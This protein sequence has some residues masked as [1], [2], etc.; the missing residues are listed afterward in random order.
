MV[1]RVGESD[2]VRESENTFS[3]FLCEAEHLLGKAIF[4]IEVFDILKV[5]EKQGL[6]RSLLRSEVGK[7]DADMSEIGCKNV[8]NVNKRIRVGERELG[9]PLKASAGFDNSSRKL[10][11]SGIV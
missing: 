8:Q 6:E 1:G 10:S 7:G 9:I 5:F 2:E 11:V 3:C 4:R